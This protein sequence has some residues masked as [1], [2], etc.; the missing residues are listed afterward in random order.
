MQNG[1][2]HSKKE[3]TCLIGRNGRDNRA[4]TLEIGHVKTTIGSYRA[5]EWMELP[6]N[7]GDVC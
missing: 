5:E 1:R 4:E 2:A 6:Q 7:W 3:H